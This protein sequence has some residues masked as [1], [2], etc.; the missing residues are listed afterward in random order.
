MKKI[1]TLTF[2]LGGLLFGLNLASA[3]HNTGNYYVIPTYSSYTYSVGCNTYR[4]DPYFR[5]SSLISSTC[6]YGYN[7][8][9]TNYNSYNYSYTYPSYSSTYYYPSY[10]NS[11]YNSYPSNYSP[12]DN[13]N[14]GYNY[15]GYGS[16]YGYDYYNTNYYYPYSSSYYYGN[17]PTYQY[18]YNYSN[19]YPTSIQNVPAPIL[20]WN[21]S[22]YSNG[23]NYYNNSN[24][25][26][27]Y[28]GSNI[29]CY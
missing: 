5:T 21:T 16:T 24:S 12:Y 23:Y 29:A 27:R 7:N 11:Y 1:I 15:Y 10:T 14:Y 4:Y 3:G 13:Y 20:N 28:I 22:S 17:T 26:C 8:Y 2:V 18:W 25:G 19:G 9:G 6:S